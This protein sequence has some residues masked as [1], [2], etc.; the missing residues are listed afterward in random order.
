[1][2]LEHFLTPYAKINC[3]WIQ[4]LNVRPET[5]KILE[6]NIGNAFF[7]INH[8]KILFDPPR[9]IIE[10]K[11]TRLKDNSQN[12]RKYL[13]MKY[14]TND[15]SPKCISSSYSSILEKQTAQS[16]TWIE[17]LNRHFSKEDI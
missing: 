2:K 14:L 12:K 10:I 15:F 17:D 7:G 9:R 1:M 11:K 3:K 6:K 16:K 13:Q 4:E 5:I 8:S